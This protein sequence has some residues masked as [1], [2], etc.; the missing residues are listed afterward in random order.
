MLKFGKGNTAPKDRSERLTQLYGD[1]IYDLCASIL[2]DSAHAQ[3]AFR[4]VSR[5][6][7]TQHPTEAFDRY[8]RAWVLR[9]AC[10]TLRSLAEQ[11]GRKLTSAEQ[12]LMDS[13][14][15]AAE[16]IKNFDSYFHRLHTN[17]QFLLL[18]KDKFGI[19]Y[20][21][22]AAALNC[23]EGAL[24]V[25]RHQALGALQEWIWEQS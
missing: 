1:L 3:N 10:D 4:T 11:H 19:P 13:T 5:A 24:K 7:A 8:E 6:I 18:L 22:V 17:D 2:K 14:T 25:Q 20:P 12:I 9:I 16:R 15:G 21:E 23:P